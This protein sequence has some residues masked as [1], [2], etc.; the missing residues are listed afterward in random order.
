MARGPARAD[1]MGAGREPSA[2]P[3]RRDSVTAREL[4]M[5]EPTA[6]GA[7]RGA[8]D[9]LAETLWLATDGQVSPHEPMPVHGINAG[10]P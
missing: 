5:V 8:V 2:R 4:A 7:A 9:T 3:V 10:R 1:P 6:M